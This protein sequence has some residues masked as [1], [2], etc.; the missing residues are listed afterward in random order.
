IPPIWQGYIIA[1]IDLINVSAVAI[2]TSILIK[3]TSSSPEMFFSMGAVGIFITAV[4]TC[5]EGFKR[6]NNLHDVLC[7][8]GF[9]VGSIGYNIG[10]IITMKLLPASIATIIFTFNI[11]QG[12]LL[13]YTIFKSSYSGH[14]NILELLGCCLVIFSIVLIPVQ[15]I[16]LD[17]NTHK[18][19]TLREIVLPLGKDVTLR[20]YKTFEFPQLYESKEQK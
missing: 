13:Q 8:I 1:F 12:I 9:I 7:I 18:Q 16:C 14:S 15:Q 4:G 10:Y 17:K 19:T 6:P 5:F 11:V 3:K 2:S 20:K